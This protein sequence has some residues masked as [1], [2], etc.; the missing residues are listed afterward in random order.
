MLEFFRD[1]RGKSISAFLLIAEEGISDMKS[2][3][4]FLNVDLV[5]NPG[6][7]VVQVPPDLARALEGCKYNLNSP[8]R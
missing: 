1:D 8:T 4:F 6:A 5:R 2:R 3:D 7:S